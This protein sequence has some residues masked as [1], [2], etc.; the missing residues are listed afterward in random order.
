MKFKDERSLIKHIISGITLSII[1]FIFI[2]IIFESVLIIY[3]LGHTLLGKL[4]IVCLQLLGCLI[5][6]FIIYHLFIWSNKK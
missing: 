1:L 3:T 6:G 5:F 4:F 2:F